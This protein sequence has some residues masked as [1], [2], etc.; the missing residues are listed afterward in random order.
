MLD[1][2][3][4]LDTYFDA[5]FDAAGLPW[6]PW[7]GSAFRCSPNRTIVLGESIYDY[8]GG[9]AEVRK[10]I[11]GKHSLRQ[12]QLGHGIHEKHKSR[13]LRNFARAFFLKRKISLAERELLWRQVIYHNLVPRMMST[14][15]QRPTEQDYRDGWHAFLQLAQL[16]GAQRCIVYGLEALKIDALKSVL[17]P[18]AL[19]AHE[20]LPAV[21]RNRPVRLLVQLGGQPL[22]LLFIRHPSAFFQWDEWGAVMRQ[23][24]QNDGATVHKGVVGSG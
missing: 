16:T 5:V 6:L 24:L 23:F 12:R 18:S 2:S 15:K 8:S 14:L 11:L 22:H 9:K 19:L 10:R 7:V 20:R 13:Y 21:G 3:P 17:S 1:D 4:Y